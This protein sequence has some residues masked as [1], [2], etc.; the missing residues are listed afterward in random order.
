MKTINKIFVKASA[1]I[2]C[3]LLLLNFIPFSVLA[4]ETNPF[5]SD[6]LL[7]AKIIAS[8]SGNDESVITQNKRVMGN[9][10]RYI[11]TFKENAA[12]SAIHNALKGYS[13]RLLAN[14]EE[15]VF[16]VYIKDK[17]LFLESNGGIVKFFEEDVKKELSIIPNDTFAYTDELELLNMYSAWDVTFGSEKI[18][19]AV[20]DSGVNR[21]H[22]DL[23]NSNILP[24]YD[25]ISG[26]SVVNI[27][28]TGHGT[29]IIGIIAATWGNKE[30]CS[31]IAPNCSVMPLRITDYGGRIYTSDFLDA[32]YLAADSGAHII[33]MSLGGYVFLESENEAVQYAAEKGCI[34]IAASG[35][36]GGYGDPDG[37]KYSYPASYENVISVGAVDNF[38][39]PCSFTQYNDK[40]D[41]AAPGSN[42]K[43]LDY[44]GGY[45]TSSGTSFSTAYV[46][47]AAALAL[48]V[49]DEG[50]KINSEEFAHLL[51]IT[52]YGEKNDKTGNGILDVEK[53]LKNANVPLV[54]GVEEGKI[55]Y[56]NV[57]IFFNRGTAIL[58]GEEFKSGDICKHT[59][60]H[61][62]TVVDGENVTEVCFVT[63]N[64]PLTYKLIHKQ[65]YSY[66]EFTRGSATL[67]GA[68]YLSGEKI[69]DDGEHIFVLTGQYGN[70]ITETFS[71]SFSPPVIYGI[72]DGKT[73][74]YPVRVSVATN[75][76]VFLDGESMEN[77]FTV[78]KNGNH[79]LVV[80]QRGNVTQTVNFT[81][82][83][84]K[85]II[86]TS[87]AGADAAMGFGVIAVWNKGYKGIR[88]YDAETFS[89]IKYLNTGEALTAVHFGES[90]IYV[91]GTNTLYAIN[92]ENIS[93]TASLSKLYTFGFPVTTADFNGETMYFSENSAIN[94]GYIK[95]LSLD[96][97][98]ETEICFIRSSPNCLSYDEST[99]SVAFGEEEKEEI[100]VAPASGESVTLYSPFGNTKGAFIFKN[101]KLARGGKVFSTIENKL[102]FAADDEN[103]LYFDGT[104]LV[105]EKGTYNIETYETEGIH[106]ETLLSV[107]YFDGTYFAA[108]GNSS[109]YVS[110][111]LP[112]NINYG[113]LGEQSQRT[114][115][116][117]YLPLTKDIS[118]AAVLGD[119]LLVS[120]DG[121]MV[122][123]LDEQ[124]LELKNTIFLPFSGGTL[125]SY[126]DAVY[127]FSKDLPFVAVYS[128]GKFKV[129]NLN[130]EISDIAATNDYILIISGKSLMVYDKEGASI[131][132]FDG[133]KYSSVTCTKDG[134]LAIAAGKT[135]IYYFIEAISLSKLSTVFFD[136]VNEV[137]ENIFC[138]D[139]YLY[140]DNYA[141]E[142]GNEFSQIRLTSKIYGRTSETFL[143]ADGLVLNGSYISASNKK[144]DVF[145]L[146]EN[147]DLYLFSDNSLMITKNTYGGDYFSL[148]KITGVE[149]GALYSSSV[150]IN[151]SKGKGFLDGKPIE[152]GYTVDEGGEHVLF[153]YLPYGLYTEYRFSI[154]AS[155]S[156][157][158]IKGG[159]AAMKTN[160]TVKFYVEFFPSGAITTDVMFYS[161]GD[162]IITQTDGTVT[163]LKEG[164]ATLY[165]ATPDGAIVTSIKITV[166]LS[167]LEF[168]SSNYVTDRNTGI[169]SQIPSGTTVERLLGSLKKDIRENAHIYSGNEKVYDTIVK[170]GME[171]VLLNQNGDILDKL[172]ISVAGDC[173]GDGDVDI[174]DLAKATEIMGGNNVDE[175]FVKSADFSN[176]G[177][178]DVADT[179]VYK[180]IIFGK[181]KTVS[182]AETQKTS[183]EGEHSLVYT[184]DKNGAVTLTLWLKGE[185]INGVSGTLKYDAETLT[186]KSMEKIEGIYGTNVGEGYVS[187][188]AVFNSGSEEETIKFTFYKNEEETFSFQM[189]NLFIA[190]SETKLLS[191]A[192]SVYVPNE[193]SKLTSLVPL[194]GTLSPDFSP[195]VFYYTL[196]LPQNTERV[197]FSWE[198]N[199]TISILGNENIKDGSVITVTADDKEYIIKV[200]LSTSSSQKLVKKNNLWWLLTIIPVVAASAAIILFFKKRK[201]TSNIK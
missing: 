132:T 125:K 56:D 1:F 28:S 104:K 31:G 65:E 36:E 51:S 129:I 159:N 64:L 157:I 179:F 175:V 77:E 57:Q 163:A 9:F 165:A 81:V 52:A 167:M 128:E 11:V 82:S 27:D 33:N 100:Y 168:T 184:V 68:P 200:K 20:P 191:S 88:I 171:L 180:E 130:K 37:G 74:N 110:S 136:A 5:Q 172:L 122:F 174:S 137:S 62:L 126:G 164:E 148:P 44:A 150:T 153:I 182:V 12:F 201:K 45:K 43:L 194:Q 49:L 124:T 93:S 119:E 181:D 18:I 19:V 139:K 39:Y 85:N 13:Y 42:L 75:G 147:A 173:N 177:I 106:A 80:K 140:I 142:I 47:G 26:E 38:G 40:V 195:D 198:S 50:I 69:T 59:G 48:S 107:N 117:A 143:T 3:F 152:N 149:N 144:G 112:S 166:L 108:F 134:A 46:S 14:S 91:C 141:Y 16:L 187:F 176:N 32:I 92:G 178:I 161:E 22:T 156:R 120:S 116:T 17:D 7:R 97:F 67:N 61:T 185:C 121:N 155:I 109:L 15:R 190:E 34:L 118:S 192:T 102:L 169:I 162:V 54:S 29:N 73:Y 4:L 145:V 89:L 94:W 123:V 99:N 10:D 63:D 78:W 58:D 151:F 193:V 66:V 6:D 86:S 55:Y 87:V 158:E 186:F 103:A 111:F 199:G 70:K 197:E 71:L 24:G 60:E 133:N 127:A 138:D 146:N 72:E 196:T 76:N 83:Y 189:E 2:I 114:D 170:T 21:D 183:F 135:D 98:T 131:K 101:G 53:V 35:N 84:D 96:S 115:F 90:Q 154:D 188:F 160:D 113:L 95:K 79:T 25:F 105:T 23:K 8:A 30:G 41:I